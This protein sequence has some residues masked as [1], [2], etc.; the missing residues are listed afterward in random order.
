MNLTSDQERDVAAWWRE[1]NI[2]ELCIA[3]DHNAGVDQMLASHPCE[4]TRPVLI[5]TCRHCGVMSFFDAMRIIRKE[6]LPAWSLIWPGAR[7]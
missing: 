7:F 2:R 5:R 6:H 4:V 3:C 1:K